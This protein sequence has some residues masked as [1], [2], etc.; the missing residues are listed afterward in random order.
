M[1]AKTCLEKLSYVGTLS[2]AT[3]DAEGAPQLRCVSAIH[4][5]PDALYF[6]TARGKSFCRELERDGRVQLL[7]PT[8]LTRN[9]PIWPTSTPAAPGASASSLKSGI[10]PWSISIWASARFFGKP[11]P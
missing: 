10:W 8:R 4:Y 7:G 2:A 6:F 11:T 1:D 3:V 5:E 9:R